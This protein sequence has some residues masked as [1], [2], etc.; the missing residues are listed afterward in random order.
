MSQGLFTLYRFYDVE[1]ALIYVGQTTNPS[2]RISTHR[3]EKAWWTEVGSIEVEHCA[4]KEH[5]DRA[6]RNAIIAE[7]PR[8]NVAGKPPEPSAFNGVSTVAA[9]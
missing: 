1:G 7:R 3:S 2:A 4:C 6:E 5:L 8:Y 9:A